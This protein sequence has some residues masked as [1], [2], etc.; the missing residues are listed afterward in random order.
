MKMRCKVF[1]YF[2]P[3]KIEIIFLQK[4]LRENFYAAKIISLAH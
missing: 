1:R 2:A 4:Y 3:Q